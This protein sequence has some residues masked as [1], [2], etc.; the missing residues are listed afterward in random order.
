VNPDVIILLLVAGSAWTGWYVRGLADRPVD[1][2]GTLI[3]A[4]RKVA[5]R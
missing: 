2:F 5:G 4:L 1:E 3:D